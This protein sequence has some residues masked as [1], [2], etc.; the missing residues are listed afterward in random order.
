[1]GRGPFLCTETTPKPKCSSSSRTCILQNW[2]LNIQKCMNFQCPK[3]TPLELN[4]SLKYKGELKVQ[5]L[6]L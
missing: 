6:V 4:M 3:Y 1:M 2:E 5:F